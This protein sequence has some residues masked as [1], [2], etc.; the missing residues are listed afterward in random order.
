MYRMLGDG[1]CCRSKRVRKELSL[2]GCAGNLKKYGK[3]DGAKHPS[4]KRCA[5][6]SSSV[7][8]RRSSRSNLRGI[9]RWFRESLS[10]FVDAV[11]GHVSVIHED[12]NGGGG[13]GG[14]V[15]IS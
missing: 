1:P 8:C 4:L 7:S 14:R 15:S 10:L 9:I 3:A 12:E 13:G 5:V 2:G 6:T 11:D